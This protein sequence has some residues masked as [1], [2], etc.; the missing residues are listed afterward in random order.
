[1][2]FRK[3]P[4]VTTP[5]Q[6]RSPFPEANF[7]RDVQHFNEVVHDQARV[8]LAQINGQAP[9]DGSIHH[10]LLLAAPSPEDRDREDWYM[11][12][13][14]VTTVQQARQPLV[15]EYLH[16][17]SRAITDERREDPNPNRR[18][19]TYAMQLVFRVGQVANASNNG[20]VTPLN[21]APRRGSH[22]RPNRPERPDS[23]A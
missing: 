16:A 21:K 10:T 19:D 3:D 4:H 9:V 18:L 17:D 20:R 11:R 5:D 15:L 6:E 14:G 23:V 13:V 1:M 2:S 7:F 12:K 22:E 8:A